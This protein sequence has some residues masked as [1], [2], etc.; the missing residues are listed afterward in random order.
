MRQT[1]VVILEPETIRKALEQ[2]RRGG[3]AYSGMVQSVL[4]FVTLLPVSFG[5]DVSIGQVPSE[6]VRGVLGTVVL[7]FFVAA[8]W[9]GIRTWHRWRLDGV[10]AI[11]AEFT[12]D[13][14]KDQEVQRDQLDRSASP[15]VLQRSRGHGA[16]VT[17]DVPRR[18]STRKKV[19]AERD[20]TAV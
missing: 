7:G 11:L 13:S 5:Q 10:S 14:E 1:N 20:L 9:Q 4:A 15:S 2:A 12:S 8:I 17:A 19:K 3:F 16:D 6:I 18:T